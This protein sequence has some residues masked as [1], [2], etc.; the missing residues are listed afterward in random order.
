MMAETAREVPEKRDN[1]TMM[2]AFHAEH[3]ALQCLRVNG[4]VC[5]RV[6]RHGQGILSAFDRDRLGFPTKA[7]LSI[8]L[9]QQLGQT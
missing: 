8:N 9:L 4:R 3:D 7:S 6:Q 2:P 1:E 5:T